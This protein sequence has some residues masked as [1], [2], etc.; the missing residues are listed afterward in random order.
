MVQTIPQERRL[1][2]KEANVRT[3]RMNRL[4]LVNYAVLSFALIATSLSA[5]TEARGQQAVDDEGKPEETAASEPQKKPEPKKKTSIFD[6]LI[7]N[8]DISALS[9]QIEW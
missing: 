2:A 3:V 7:I 6:H 8:F 5:A 1:R 9:L 4:K